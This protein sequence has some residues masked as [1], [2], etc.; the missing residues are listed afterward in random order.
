MVVK[1]NRVPVENP[2]G[3]LN[4]LT[5]IKISYKYKSYV[6]YISPATLL[7][8]GSTLIETDDRY[9]LASGPSQMALRRFHREWSE[10]NKTIHFSTNK[11][12]FKVRITS[13]EK[14]LDEESPWLIAGSLPNKQLIYIKYYADDTAENG[15]SANAILCFWFHLETF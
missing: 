5:P 11:E 3:V 12:H 4:W 13:I 15:S 14:P 6:Y 7:G 9:V 10:R 2:N 8:G 1:K